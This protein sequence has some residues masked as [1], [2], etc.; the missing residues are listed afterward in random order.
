MVKPT[1]SIKKQ[2]AAFTKEETVVKPDIQAPLI[3]KGAVK[4]QKPA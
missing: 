4:R 2:A 3:L 1:H